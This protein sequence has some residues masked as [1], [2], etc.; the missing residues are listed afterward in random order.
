MIFPIFRFLRAA[1]A[2][3]VLLLSL[4]LS[5]GVAPAFAIEKSSAPE[6]AEVYF[7]APQDGETVEA[8]FAVKFGLSGMG[9]APAGIDRQNT[10]HH[11]LLVDRVELPDLDAPLPGGDPSVRHFG[12]GQTETELALEPGKH[13]LQLVLGNYMHIPHDRPV[14]SEPISVTVK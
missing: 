10:G 2:T 11:H 6:T 1:L 5:V 13:T 7:I 4:G 3:C 12:G 14:V 8:T 9:I